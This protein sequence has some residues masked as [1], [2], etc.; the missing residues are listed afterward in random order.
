MLRRG[1]SEESCRRFFEETR[2]RSE[3]GP[4]FAEA[5]GSISRFFDGR[6]SRVRDAKLVPA[7][8][9]QQAELE[10][11]VILYGH[12][13]NG[14]SW[15]GLKNFESI[16][17]RLKRVLGDRVE[18]IFFGA[19]NDPQAQMHLAT[20][21]YMPWLIADAELGR[22]ARFLAD[23]A[24]S[25]E[26]QAMVFSRDGAPMLSGNAEDL[27]STLKFIDELGG[28][29]GLMYPAN[30]KSWKD[31]QHYFGAI[32][33]M[34]FTEGTTE[35]EMIGNPLNAATL[36]EYGVGRIV[37][38]LT[39]SE[40][41]EVE[42]VSL[43]PESIVPENL[44]AALATAIKRSGVF[45]LAF[46]KGEAARGIFRY[47]LSVPPE[48]IVAEADAAWLSGETMHEVILNDWFRLRPIHVP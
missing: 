25:K 2:D 6:V 28:L 5:T 17:H 9:S 10:L 24:R 46:S 47:D 48:D 32:R 35:P 39:I 22:R 40:S 33:G 11:L 34:R 23:Y 4:P 44:S 15:R 12:P 20:K 19:V 37:A 7:D 36:R 1:L 14:N 45:L 13:H 43:L 8:F 29:A 3:L 27:A 21:M 31:R 42:N 16:Y 18:L 30:P 26:T 38:D 41:G